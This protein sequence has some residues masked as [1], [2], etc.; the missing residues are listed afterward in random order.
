MAAFDSRYLMDEHYSKEEQIE[1]TYFVA[2]AER[3]EKG[4][5]D[6]LSFDE[7]CFNH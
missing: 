7:N 4:R 2:L 3:G 5:H 1:L 6:Y